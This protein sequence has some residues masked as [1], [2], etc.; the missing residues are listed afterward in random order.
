V[1]NHLR[2][3]N[4]RPIVNV[5]AVF[6]ILLLDIP[7]YPAARLS[8]IPGRRAAAAPADALSRCA[9][10]ARVVRPERRRPA[11][12]V[13]LK[14]TPAT[15]T[16]SRDALSGGPAVAGRAAGAA[17]CAPAQLSDPTIRQTRSRRSRPPRRWS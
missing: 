15:P 9:I 5:V 7:V 10:G 6:L 3:P 11:T 16:G 4:Q 13:A 14:A 1:F 2:L 12:T 17:A 8:P